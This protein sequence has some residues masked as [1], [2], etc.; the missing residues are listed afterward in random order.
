MKMVMKVSLTK[1]TVVTG[2]VGDH[3]VTLANIIEFY[4]VLEL[5]DTNLDAS[6]MPILLVINGKTI[7]SF[8]NKNASII[9]N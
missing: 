3:Q 8:K 7:I 6:V 9:S 5:H 1:D 4:I 2:L